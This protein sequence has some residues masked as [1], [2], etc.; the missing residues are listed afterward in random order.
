MIAVAI[1][2]T[3]AAPPSGAFE[4]AMRDSQ[5]A[6]TRGDLVGA[7]NFCREA[8]E[9]AALDPPSELE[10]ELR[11]ARAHGRC[12]EI[13][14]KAK[15]PQAALRS[16]REAG[17]RAGEDRA[18]RKRFL[19]LRAKAAK[20]AKSP[21]EVEKSEALR[22][23]DE[24]LEAARKRRGLNEKELA[25]LAEELD[26]AA[27]LY[28]ADGDTGRAELAKAIEILVSVRSG[29]QNMIGE[30]RAIAENPK[31]GRAAKKAALEALWSAGEA[32]KD[33]ELAASSALQLN[34]LAA[35]QRPPAQRRY[36]R[37]SGLDALC[38]R[39]DAEQKKSG[40]CARL[41]KRVTGDFTFTDL[42]KVPAK[43][44][45]GDAELAKVH[46]QLLPAIEDCVLTAAKKAVDTFANSDVEIAWAIQPKGAI[47][48]IEITPKRVRSDLEPCIRERLAWARYPRYTSQERK[49]VRVPYHLD[50]QIPY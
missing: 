32:G 20:D 17:E 28:R 50:E 15:E 14:L 6:L 5:T 9:A 49:A 40:A 44:E 27:A 38:A 19:E 16:F 41:E 30:A 43:K 12:G 47:T 3:A 10:A 31:R 35:E 45:L 46:A 34:A 37:A 48:D 39:Y 2:L 23:N 25:A 22:K 13:E 18:L 24:R 42:S 8:I 7:K 21:A 36:V 4:A 11:A 26:E 1:L 33:L 29:R